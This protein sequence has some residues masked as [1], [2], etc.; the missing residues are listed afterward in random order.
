MSVITPRVS[1]RLHEQHAP[2][3][4]A[5][6]ECKQ[7]IFNENRYLYVCHRYASTDTDFR[8]HLPYHIPRKRLHKLVHRNP[9]A[10][11]SAI[12]VALASAFAAIS[13]EPSSVCADQNSITTLATSPMRPVAA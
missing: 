7:A 5:P 4:S 13:L 1:V 8:I 9:S 10:I 3:N 6:E 2:L 11:P 12:L